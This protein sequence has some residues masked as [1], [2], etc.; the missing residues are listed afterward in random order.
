M[1][2][3]GIGFVSLL[4]VIG[5]SIVFGMLVGGKLNAPKT[6]FAAEPT[7]LLAPAPVQPG[8]GATVNFADVVDVALPAVVNIASMFEGDEEPRRQRPQNMEE[9]Y[10]WFFGPDGFEPPREEERQ[11]RPQIGAGSGF[12][13][14]P[15]GYI[16]TNNHVV[17]EADKIQVGFQGGRE[18]EARL[19]GS[20]PSIDLALLKV[21]VGEDE[22]P[23]LP[24][25]DSDSLR[26]GEWVIAIGNPLDYDHTVTVGVLSAKRRRL[27]IGDRSGLVTFLQTDAAINFGNSGGPLLNARGQVIGINVAITRAGMAEGIGFA[28]PINQ[29][30]AV[31]DQLR[32]HGFVRRGYLGITMNNAGIDE[33]VREYFGLPD[34]RGVL[35]E[36]VTAG[37]PADDAGIRTDDII[38]KVDDEVIEGN[39]DLIARI[40]SRQPGEDVMLEIIR[41]GEKLRIGVTLTERPQNPGAANR[42]DDRRSEEP[43]ER[44]SSGLGITVEELS[45]QSRRIL[46]L[47]DNQ[48]GVLVTEVEFGS[49]ARQ[50][51]IAPR[52]VITAINDEPI[53]NIGDWIDEVEGLSSGSAVKLTVAF[54]V[55]NGLRQRTIF[56]RV[57]ASGE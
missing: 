34:G 49:Q 48:Q 26:V 19:I 38:R 32:E 53:R 37:G 31:V 11:R 22:L 36:D 20:D 6:M 42:L 14:S 54:N 2:N 28:L 56:M 9:F 25:G 46:G 45:M 39:D 55:G 24:L 52:M 1:S 57:P 7:P 5:V 40:S 18:M 35:V 41:D 33:D 13:I 30:S 8:A 29:A 15:D 47:D 50:K 16:L 12:V 3:R 17:D 51:G 4:A 21:D 43:E 10:R 23:T 27:E 44:E